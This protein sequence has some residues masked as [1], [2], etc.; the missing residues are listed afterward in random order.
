MTLLV[1]GS[2]RVD[3]GKTTFSTGLIARTG[4]VGFKPRAGNDYWFHQDDYREAVLEGRLYGKD[5]RRLAAASPGSLAPEDINPVHR[6]WRPAP[7]NGSG[8]LGQ[9]QRSFVVDRVGDGYVVNGTVKTP[10]LAREHLPL[11]DAAVVES[12]DA[13]NQLMQRHHVTRLENLSRRITATD[14]AV[15]ESYSDVARPVRG[16]EPNA[17]A[18]VDPT[19]ARIYEGS[20]YRKCCAIATGA[21]GSFTG[22]LEERVPSVIDLADPVA[23]VELPALSS[24]ERSDPETVATAYETAYEELLDTAGW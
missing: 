2:E 18:V 21:E 19:R 6:L 10:E 1:V 22:Q 17:V 23:T 15:V 16:I 9:A 14:R 4:A 13:F 3:A 8:L 24:A 12:V 7:G 5:A 20:R 11:S